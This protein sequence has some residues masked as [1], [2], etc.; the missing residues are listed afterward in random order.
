MLGTVVFLV[1]CSVVC[2]F[3]WCKQCC[4]GASVAEICCVVVVVAC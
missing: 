3:L 4:S 2:V 1:C